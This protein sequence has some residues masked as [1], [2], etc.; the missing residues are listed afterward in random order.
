[1]SALN[2]L[3]GYVV[4]EIKEKKKIRDDLLAIPDAEA[5]GWE[6]SFRND[7]WHNPAT[8]TKGGITVW[9]TGR[10][11]RASTFADGRFGV[12]RIYYSSLVDV[13]RR[14]APEPAL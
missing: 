10:D 13:L 9:S 11:W 4:D 1:M 2:L 5:A 12:P 3:P 8:F 14:E 6:V 7:H